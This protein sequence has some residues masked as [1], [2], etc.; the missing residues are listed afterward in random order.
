[1]KRPTARDLRNAFDA[2]V[3]AVDP[4]TAVRSHL[5][6]DDGSVVLGG[7]AIG[8]F[9]PDQIVVVGIGKAAVPMVREICDVTGA[10]GAVVA[11]PYS[12]EDVPGID[13]HIGGHPL[14]DASSIEAGLA[15]RRAVRAVPADGL[16]IAAISGGGSAAADIPVDGVSID[17][18]QELNHWL[19][20]SGLEIREL[21][22]IRAAVS[23]FKA[24]GL[25]AEAGSTVATMVLSDVVGGGPEFVASG[26]TIPS[27]LGMRARE[28]LHGQ[29]GADDLPVGIREAIE[30][31]QRVECPVGP[32][33]TVGSPDVSAQAA[34][35]YL[36]GQ[37]F[38]VSVE[39]T[40]LTG[41]ARVMADRLLGGS[42]PGVVGIA[43][44]E[45]TVTVVGS[46]VG[47]RNQEAALAVMASL[48]RTGGI[49]AAL[50][51][52]GIDGPTTAAGAIVGPQSAA[53][54]ADAGWDVD[55][56]L[57]ENNAN[58]VLADAEALVV[59]GPTGTNVCDLWMWWT[60]DQVDGR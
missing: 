26:P 57:A 7:H 11:T 10:R 17:D 30:R 19:L 58:P 50:G 53:L 13:V 9:A 37:G 48:R 1:M 49:F 23:A 33:V 6:M 25:A 18:L 5:R 47:G 52:D 55:A 35:Y 59:T 21:N 16:V 43:S 28:V 34:A 42:E 4:A 54:A 32:V 36:T 22:E 60:P 41:E 29:T 15:L 2:A 45:T 24:G 20:S 8:R 31:R 46:G 3:A 44:G 40:T 38:T 12:S 56:E 39:T 27:D 51:T 14:P